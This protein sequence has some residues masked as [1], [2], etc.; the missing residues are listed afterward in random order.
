MRLIELY[1]LARG[2]IFMI[3]DDDVV[4]E[5][6]CLAKHAEAHAQNQ[7]AAI[8]GRILPGKDFVGNTADAKR[9]REYNIP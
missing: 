1:W 5:P 4:V 6:N 8:Q 2:E 3:L 7:F 9:L